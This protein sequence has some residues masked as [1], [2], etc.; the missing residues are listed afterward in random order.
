M[1]C[2]GVLRRPV[3]SG[4]SNTARWGVAVCCTSQRA[5]GGQW[6]VEVQTLHG[7]V[8]RCAAEA[9][10]EWRF[11]HC[12]VG[13]GGVLHVDSSQWGVE[14]QTLRTLKDAERYYVTEL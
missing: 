4:G 7:G 5:D 2:D 8:W 6:G 10:G 13:C 9:S 12:T 11:K 1:G 3:G 14:V